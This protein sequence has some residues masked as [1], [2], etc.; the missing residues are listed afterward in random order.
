MKFHSKFTLLLV[1]PFLFSSLSI[2]ASDH[3]EGHIGDTYFFKKGNNLVLV[4]TILSDDDEHHQFGFTDDINYKFYL[5]RNAEVLMNDPEAIKRYGGTILY[6]EKIKEDI[7]IEISFSDEGSSKIV[8]TTGL[9]P[10]GEIKI[11]SGLRDDPFIRSGLEKKNIMAIVV[12]VPMRAVLGPKDSPTILCWASTNLKNKNDQLHDHGGHPYRSQQLKKLNGLHP[13]L[14]KQKLKVEPDVFI[15][16]TQKATAFPNGR[17]LEDDVV[18]LLPDDIVTGKPPFPTENDVPFLKIFPYLAP[19]YPPGIGKIPGPDEHLDIHFAPMAVF[20]LESE[21]GVP[22]RKVR[23]RYWIM[24]PG[25]IIKNHEHGKRPAIVY[26][27][28]GE[29]IETKKNPPDGNITTRTIK[30]HEA[31][32]EPTDIEHWWIN[33]SNQM[34]RMVAIDIPE[35]SESEAME[36]TRFDTTTR[37]PDLPFKAPAHSDE[38]KIIELGA[39]DLELLFPEEPTLNGYQMRARRYEFLPDQTSELYNAIKNPAIIY[40]ISGDVLEYRSDQIASIAQEA[41]IKKQGDFSI[42]QDGVSYY[43][44]NPTSELAQLLVVDFVKQ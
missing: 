19:S 16:D 6:P 27:L 37:P 11:F 13:S 33:K 12:E 18:D 25:G 26:L 21:I 36:E 24:A 22:N 7:M 42:A 30:A 43:W 20:D 35:P 29:V 4:M 34:V 15:Y 9:Y 23:A 28:N 10:N 32:L 31:A 3:G 38:I 44:K 5:D 1:A 41:L 2:L 14:H 17:T 40:V 8:S 39:H